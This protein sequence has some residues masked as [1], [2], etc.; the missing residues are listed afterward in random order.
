MTTNNQSKIEHTRKVLKEYQQIYDDLPYK[1]GIIANLYLNAV[2]YFKSR[3]T[4]LENHAKENNQ[5]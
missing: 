2:N 1:T 5:R 3:L 4:K